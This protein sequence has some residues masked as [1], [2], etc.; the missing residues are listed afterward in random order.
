MRLI[1]HVKMLSRYLSNIQSAASQFMPDVQGESFRARLQ[2]KIDDAPGVDLWAFSSTP[3]SQ[4]LMNIGF[5]VFSKFPD[6]YT[7]PLIP[8]SV[9]NET[10]VT[11]L[12]VCPYAPNP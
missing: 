1:Q 8:I 7:F 11:D 4:I 10:V 9:R 2:R 3:I 6:L 5:K 12:C